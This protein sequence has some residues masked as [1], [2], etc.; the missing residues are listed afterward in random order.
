V[1]SRIPKWI[2][3]S[4]AAMLLAACSADTSVLG[5]ASVDTQVQPVFAPSRSNAEVVTPNPNPQV[6]AQPSRR[7]RYAMAA[8]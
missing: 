1:K 8:S 6:P 4:C 2:L 3:L 7:G 5:P